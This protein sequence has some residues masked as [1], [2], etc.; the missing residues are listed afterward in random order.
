[1]Q[2]PE[3]LYRNAEAPRPKPPE[4]PGVFLFSENLSRQGLQFPK[5]KRMI[6]TC[7]KC[8][9]TNDKRGDER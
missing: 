7:G 2:W 5:M 4:T 3:T 9:T 8:E 6:L 1:M